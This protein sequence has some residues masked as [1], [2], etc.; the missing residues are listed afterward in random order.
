MSEDNLD[1]KNEFMRTEA[2][3]TDDEQVLFIFIL[4]IETWN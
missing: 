2:I 4:N 1:L 3:M